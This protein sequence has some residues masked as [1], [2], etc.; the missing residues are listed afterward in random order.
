[1][2]AKLYS[3]SRDCGQCGGS[4]KGGCS[5]ATCPHSR[6]PDCEYNFVDSPHVV[7]K[8]CSPS[9]CEICSNPT[10]ELYVVGPN[11][12][13]LLS[14]IGFGGSVDN[15]KTCGK[16]KTIGETGVCVD[17]ISKQH[18]RKV[19]KTCS[20]NICENCGEYSEV[21][22]TD[23]VCPRCEARE[24]WNPTHRAKCDN[25]KTESVMVNHKGYCEDCFIYLTTHGYKCYNC[26]TMTMDG[27][28]RK[29]GAKCIE[30]S[31]LYPKAM[32]S[33]L[34]CY[35]CKP[36]CEGCNRKFMP[37]SRTDRICHSCAY[38]AMDG[39]CVSCG[40]IGK[41]LNDV[42]K[43]YNCSGERF[44]M[45][46]QPSRYW[47]VVCEQEE[48][49]T[50]KTPCEKCRVKRIICPGCNRND[51]PAISYRCDDCMLKEEMKFS[52]QEKHRNRY[53]YRS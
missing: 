31:K 20:T 29:C 4:E 24:E 6:C 21:L 36:I 10:E 9:T 13:T 11:R 38:K 32:G 49:F 47:C 2:Q 48:V 15:C 50:P 17:C 43:C 18:E 34:M 45:T 51:M 3:Y 25:C 37:I 14:S 19:C 44:A 27:I 5:Y 26:E 42:G 39:E 41:K 46:D 1:M 33:D 23:K 35:D 52:T 40:D 30:C 7:C 28:C 12:A 16:L 53:A 8:E 22:N